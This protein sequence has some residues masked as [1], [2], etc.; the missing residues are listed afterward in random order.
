[1]NNNVSCYFFRDVFYRIIKM[2]LLLYD[3]LNIKNFYVLSRTGICVLSCLLSVL[4]VMI[5]FTLS[6]LKW[7]L[8]VEWKKST[9]IG[10]K[11]LHKFLTK[12][13]AKQMVS[14]YMM[15][16]TITLSKRVNHKR[17]L[18]RNYEFGYIN[19]INLNRIHFVY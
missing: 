7:Y 16:P 19:S 13:D 8:N 9:L 14:T 10:F 12:V 3:V 18:W 11:T 1:M 15:S 4:L 17:Q 5:L 6:L 2:N